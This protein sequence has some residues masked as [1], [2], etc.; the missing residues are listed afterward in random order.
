ME[1]RYIND[2]AR[3]ILTQVRVTAGTM[4]FLSWGVS[5]KRAMEF[6]GMASLDMVVSGAIFKGHVLIS[7]NEGDDL[8]E[9]RL[10]KEARIVTKTL[11]G[12]YAEDLGKIIDGLVERAPEMTDEEY[13]AA[14][15]ADTEAKI[16]KHNN[17]N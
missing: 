9:I 7:Y 1:A 2:T 3:E 12:V 15:M 4:V 10:F 8:Y 16:Q 11:K 14:A 17:E 5:E 6:E 13:A